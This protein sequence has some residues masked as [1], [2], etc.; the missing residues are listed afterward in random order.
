MRD[1][2]FALA[3]LM[4]IPLAIAKPVNAYYLWGWT[5]VLIPTSYFFGFMSGARMNLLFA[6]LT[7]LMVLLGRVKWSEYQPNRVTWLYLLFLLHGTMSFALG[8]PGNPLNAQ[9][10]EIL[11]KVMVFCLLMPLFINSRLRLHVMIIVI[12]LGMGLHGVLDG[13]KTIASGGGHKMYGPLNSMIEDRNHLSAALAS[14]LPLIYYLYLHSRHRLIRWGFLAAFALVALAI[15]GGGSR[16][17]FL[18]MGIVGFWLIVTTRHK[19]WA[20]I[21]VAALGISFFAF[22]PE[23]WTD[24]LSTIQTAD[25]DESFMGRVIA[26]KVGSA[27]A[28]AHPVFGGGF[29]AAQIQYIWDTFKTSQGLLGFVDTPIPEFTAKAAHSI[30]FEVMGDM[31][32]VGLAI[33]L[34]ILLHAIYSRFAIKR[35]VKG[36]GDSYIWARDMADMLMLAVIAYM[37]GGAGVSLGYLEMMY[38]IVML[39][40]MLRIQVRSAS[41]EAAASKETVPK[42]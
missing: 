8:Y 3:M 25:Q 18:A 32:F 21:G 34:F 37:A 11:V 23:H 42:K 20:S 5:A 27:L 15:M 2:M 14:T 33:F 10:Y 24:R 19:V 28:M 13:L 16:G 22:A 6:I 36:L 35:M 40:E 30:Y 1:L 38:M 9:Y 29:H 17:G 12:V 31:G 39:M 7:I 4:A 26:W 41:R